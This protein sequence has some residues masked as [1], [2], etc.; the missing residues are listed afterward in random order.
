MLRK[1]QLYNLFCFIA[2]DVL[3]CAVFA[4]FGFNKIF[5]LKELGKNEEGGL[6]IISGL[7]GH[8]GNETLLHHVFFGAIR[9]HIQVWIWVFF[10]LLV[11][12]W[13]ILAVWWWGYL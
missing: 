3:R 11:V 12:V 7:G 9:E 5:S 4:F 2:Q 8:V 13:L 6:I 10:S 1:H